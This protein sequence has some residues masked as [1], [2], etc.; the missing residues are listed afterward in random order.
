MTFRQDLLVYLYKIISEWKDRLVSAS[1]LRNLLA[2]R[3][4]GEIVLS[5]EPG[6]LMKRWRE[7]FSTSQTRLAR[8]IGISLSVVSDYESGRRNNPGVKF[9]KRYIEALL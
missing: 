5:D 7:T 2:K 6:V 1:N 3:I 9:I 4:A 8:K